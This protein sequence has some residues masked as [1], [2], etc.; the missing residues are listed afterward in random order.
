MQHLKDQHESERRS[1]QQELQAKDA[2]LK[3]AQRQ[4]AKLQSEL[5]Q[6]KAKVSLA[7]LITDQ[8]SWPHVQ[9]NMLLLITSPTCLQQGP[10]ISSPTS[11][12]WSACLATF[13]VTY[14]SGP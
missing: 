3:K 12:L 6:P 14:I 13:Q 4:L 1:A 8:D 11:L 2:E 9:A 7:I 10:P 5:K